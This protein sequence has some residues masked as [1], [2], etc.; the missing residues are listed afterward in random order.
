MTDTIEIKTLKEAAAMLETPIPS[1]IIGAQLK[2]QAVIEMLE[3]QYKTKV[4]AE[5]KQ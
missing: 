2:I 3:N 5:K 4:R 1:A